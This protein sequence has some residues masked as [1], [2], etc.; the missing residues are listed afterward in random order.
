M[1]V[2]FLLMVFTDGHIYFTQASTAEMD[3]ANTRAACEQRV[4]EVEP[5]VVGMAGKVDHYKIGCTFVKGV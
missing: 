5:R 3:V 4:A 1:W 2:A